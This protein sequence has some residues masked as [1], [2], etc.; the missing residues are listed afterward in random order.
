MSDDKPTTGHVS[1]SP[2]F[3]SKPPEWGRSVLRDEALIRMQ[4]AL[5]AERALADDLAGALRAAMRGQYTGNALAALAR[6]DAS[7]ATPKETDQ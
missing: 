3:E 1:W 5:A 4:R 6:Y 2:D 7:R